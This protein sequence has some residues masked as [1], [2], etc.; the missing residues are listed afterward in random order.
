MPEDEDK[1][2]VESDRRRFVKGVVGS[3][4]LAGVGTATAGAIDSATEQS[5]AGGGSTKAM[6]IENTDGPAPRGM[7]QIP[8]EVE[9]GELKGVWPE[10]KEI[11]VQGQTQIIAETDNFKDTGRSYSNRWFQYCGIQSYAGLDPEADMDNF[12]RYS[13]SPP[14]SYGWQGEETSGGDIVQVSDFQDYESWGN[15]IGQ[16]GLGKPAAATWRSQGDDVDTIPVIV[17]RSPIIEEM[18]QDDEWLA[19]STDQGFMAWLNKCTHFCCVPG[20]KASEGAAKFNA[21]DDV[22]CQCHQSVYDPFSIVETT[23]TALPRPEDN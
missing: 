16:G 12:F 20:W 5:G 4:A 3:A 14:P 21:E 7:P 22:Y 13:P 19:A 2:P 23:F 8:V 17:V 10:V 9:N 1:Y 15:D 6:A 18:A 11:E